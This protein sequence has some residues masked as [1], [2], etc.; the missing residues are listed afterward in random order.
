MKLHN[1][2]STHLQPIPQRA[3]E[4][5]VAHYV[6]FWAIRMPDAHTTPLFESPFVDLELGGCSTGEVGDSRICEEETPPYDEIS[7]GCH[8][9][10]FS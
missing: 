9:L 2:L 7:Y 6:T 10:N 4:T 1:D 8:D 5:E 3:L